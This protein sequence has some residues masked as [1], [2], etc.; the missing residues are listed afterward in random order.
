MEL[1]NMKLMTAICLLL[2]VLAAEQSIASDE[3]AAQNVTDSLVSYKYRRLGNTGAHIPSQC[4]TRTKDE[5]GKVHNPCYVCHTT[6]MRPN[7]ANDPDLQLGY[8]FPEDPRTNRWTNLF[9]DRSKAVAAISDEQI[10]D[11]ISISNY[12]DDKGELILAK[13]LQNPPTEWDHNTNGKWDGFV[14]DA[15]YNFDA[16]GF[17]R[18]KQGNDTGWRAYAYYPFP[19]TFWPANGSTNDVLIRLPEA[20]RQ[21]TNGKYD[22]TVYKTNLAI[23]E[24]MMRE[25]DIRIEP[26]DEASLGGVDINKNGKID[27]ADRVVYDWSPLNNRFMW[28]VGM[29][30]DLQKDGKVH[31]AAGLLPA[32][33]EFLHTV[34]YIDAQDNGNIQLAPRIKEVRYARKRAWINYS[35]LKDSFD[36][37]VKEKHD[38]PNRLRTVLGNHEI[39]V[40]NGQG[41]TY[42]AFIEDAK[43]DLRPQTY[44]ELQ[45]CVGC[46]GGIGATRDGI[47]SFERRLGHD[48]FQH[49]WHHW[50][51]KTI[52]GLKDPLRRDGKHEYAFYLA[53]NHAGDEFRGN[54]EIW[55]K[56]FTADGILKPDMLDS[57]QNDI[58]ELL[59]PSKTRAL[60]LNKAYKAIVNEQSFILGRDA[61]ITPQPN[62]HDKVD[63]DQETGILEPVIA[64]KLSL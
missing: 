56:F 39:G 51:Q 62:V 46:H 23:L 54:M 42:A 14:P 58:S 60:L 16:E 26:V 15:W 2:P 25:Q 3:L 32:G 45:F 63:E 28:Y 19:S 35:N 47:F 48:A 4:Y 38:F 22:R 34:R 7:Y 44:E 59:W 8:A 9:K 52:K 41:W 13:N 10:R 36:S 1:F 55:E 18:N 21:N 31:I 49:G 40:S 61:T 5:N 12:F 43:G 30:Y 53:N 33:T 37:E 17:D 29:A 20:F 27:I 57:M 11:Y 50:S 6:S 24:A 64:E